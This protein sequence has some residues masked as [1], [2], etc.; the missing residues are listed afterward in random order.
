MRWRSAGTAGPA[1]VSSTGR[2][3]A[4][5]YSGAAGPAARCAR[6]PA[7]RECRRWSPPASPSRSAGCPWSRTRCASG[8]RRGRGS[9]LPPP[10]RSR[11]GLSRWSRCGWRGPPARS[12]SRA[13][14]CSGAAHGRRTLHRRPRRRRGSPGGCARSSRAPASCGLVA[15]ST[16]SGTPASSRCSSSA[17][18]PSGR[19]SAR[20]I[21]ACPRPLA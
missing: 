2:T 14:G 17:A 6:H 19:Y 9:G 5:R 11:C 1:R 7:R 18:Q 3:T 21:S 12:P 10:R 8:A 4:G 16:S 13:G 20:P 15:N